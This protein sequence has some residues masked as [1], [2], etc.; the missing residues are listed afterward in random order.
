MS[1]RA[2]DMLVR[3]FYLLIAPLWWIEVYSR[4]NDKCNEGSTK[5]ICL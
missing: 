5:V 4:S 2:R 3:I 1:N